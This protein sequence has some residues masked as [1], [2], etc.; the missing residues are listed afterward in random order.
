MLFSVLLFVGFL[1]ALLTNQEVQGQLFVLLLMLGIFWW[2]YMQ[3]PHPIQRLMQ[4]PF[5]RKRGGH[6]RQ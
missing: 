6:D 5:K 4:R 3:L 2:A 1:E